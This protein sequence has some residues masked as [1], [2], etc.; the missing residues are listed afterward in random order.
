MNPFIRFS[1]DFTIRVIQTIDGRYYGKIRC[2]DPEINKVAIIRDTSW[3]VLK[4]FSLLID[5]IKQVKK[6]DL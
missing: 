6:E 2:D 4:E 5:G 1:G 3:D